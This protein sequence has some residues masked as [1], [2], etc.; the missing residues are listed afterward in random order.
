MDVISITSFHEE[1]VIRIKSEGYDGFE[2]S[3]D[4]LEVHAE[5]NGSSEIVRG[6]AAR[7]RELGITF[8]L[9]ISLAIIK[10]QAQKCRH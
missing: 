7:F 8:V 3:L 5:K 6:I 2:V 1:K 4:D 10:R 9:Y